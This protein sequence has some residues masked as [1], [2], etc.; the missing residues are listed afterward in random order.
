MNTEEM[1][2]KVEEIILSVRRKND[3][4]DWE[5]A[6]KDIMDIIHLAEKGRTSRLRSRK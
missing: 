1:K 5:Y 4:I 2:L 6:V 3:P